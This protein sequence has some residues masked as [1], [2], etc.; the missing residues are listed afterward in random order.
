[1]IGLAAVRTEFPEIED[2]QPLSTD[3][4]QRIVLAGKRQHE[5]V[6]LKLLRAGQDPARTEREIDAVARIKSARVPTVRD[7]GKRKLGGTD[8]FY[9]VEQR[10]DGDT[11][12]AI[13]KK[14]PKPDFPFVMNAGDALLEACSEF[15]AARIVHRDVKPG[16]LMIDR[17]GKLW[18]IDLGIARVLDL[19][20]LTGTA[21]LWGV[22]T[23]GYGAPEQI[24]NLKAQINSRA[25]LFS[26]GVVLFEMLVGFN[27][28]L[29]G[30]K[31][32]MEVLRRM[33][34]ND[35]PT[36]THPKDPQGEFGL[37]VSNMGSRFP[38]RRPQNTREARDWYADI[39]KQLGV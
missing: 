22:F 16:N 2:L 5:A 21:N 35:L 37:F 27:P 23:A 8:V 34:N 4:G 15:E 39:R 31:D 10:I 9:T 28:Y 17:A 1:M 18:V 29:A 33:L 26:I 36:P 30:A 24:R 6:V 20:S 11:L 3:T 7:C 25:D 14:S 38:C 12:Q 19:P 32:G 13:L